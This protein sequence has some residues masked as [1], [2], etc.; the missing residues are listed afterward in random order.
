MAQPSDIRLLQ[1]RRMLGLAAVPSGRAAAAASI[2][3]DPVQFADALL[4]E[5]ADSDDVTSPESAADYLETRLAFFADLL[6]DRTVAA[7]RRA[8]SERVRAWQ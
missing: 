2:A 5:A 4:R 3:A 8:F 1:I 7:V 6:D